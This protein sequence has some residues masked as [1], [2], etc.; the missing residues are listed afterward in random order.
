MSTEVTTPELKIPCMVFQ[1]G[2][3][4]LI[5]FKI[6]T[7]V[8]Y[9][10]VQ[11]NRK[12]EDKME[13]YQRALATNRVAAIAKF[14]SKGYPLPLS[15]LISLDEGELDVDKKILT[16][17]DKEN[18]GWIIDGQHR[19]MGAHESKVNLEFA[20]VAFLRLPV[21]SQIFN[22]VTINKEAKGVPSSLYI[23]LLKFLPKGN[24]SDIAKNRAADIAYLLRS[25]E[26]SPFFNRIVVTTS[27]KKGQLS[28]TN[29]SR[30]IVPHFNGILNPY[31]LEEIKTILNNL[32]LGLTNVQWKLFEEPSPI[33]FQTLGFG[34]LMN[35]LQMILSYSLKLYGGFTVSNVTDLFKRLDSIDF[36]AWKSIG[37]GSGAEKIASDVITKAIAED[38]SKSGTDTSIKLF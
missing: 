9:K 5:L 27:P 36:D 2:N 34:A 22:F 38:Q 30:K 7:K 15:L 1:Q 37:T 17:P 23:D 25:D 20:V 6:E 4:E 13:G 14:I 18:I 21:E 10:I 29:F 35:S 28:L 32:Y 31:T 33:F 19:L 8:L 12:V 16:I 24:A 3:N 26:S 11:V